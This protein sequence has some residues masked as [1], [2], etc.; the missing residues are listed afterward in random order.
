LYIKNLD[1][2]F[3]DEKLRKEFTKFGTITSAKVTHQGSKLTLDCMPLANV[4]KG[5]RCLG[6]VEL[7]FEKCL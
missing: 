7:V 5:T 4:L 6:S 3:D 1:D 2:E